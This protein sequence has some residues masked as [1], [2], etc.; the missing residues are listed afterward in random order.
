MKS[1]GVVSLFLTLSTLAASSGGALCTCVSRASTKPHIFS[2]GQVP[3]ISNAGISAVCVPLR[4]S[5]DA[6]YI[7]LAMKVHLHFKV[8]LDVQARAIQA[9]PPG[10]PGSS[11][12]MN[13]PHASHASGESRG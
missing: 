12:S 6:Q 9:G 7:E 11:S 2:E 13:P 3:R 1:V 5:S 4:W 8:V 10:C